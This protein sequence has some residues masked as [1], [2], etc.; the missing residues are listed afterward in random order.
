MRF[1]NRRRPASPERLIDEVL[2]AKPSAPLF[3]HP[4]CHKARGRVVPICCGRAAFDPPA[5][6]YFLSR[7]I[8]GVARC[9]SRPGWARNRFWRGSEREVSLGGLW[10]GGDAPRRSE[11]PVG[12]SAV[13]VVVAVRRRR[14]ACPSALPR[15]R[16]VAPA[17]RPLV[18]SPLGGWHPR[19]VARGSYTNRPR[20]RRGGNR[21]SWR[22]W[23][24]TRAG[25]AL[26]MSAR[27]RGALVIKEQGEW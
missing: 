7:P 4:C 19:W 21:P 25:V 3:P 18:A 5:S 12:V 9:C 15:F 27:Q 17:G 23:C 10:V 8:A 22:T 14:P 2:D 20:V 13:R 16:G 26:T 1:H 6:R 24:R 11:D